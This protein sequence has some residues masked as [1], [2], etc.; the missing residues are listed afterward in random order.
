[1][2]VRQPQYAAPIDWSNPI[3]RGLAVAWVPGIATTPAART[4]V[5]YGA[6]AVGYQGVAGKG[7]GS[8]TFALLPGTID[9][10]S[11]YGSIASADGA[12]TFLAVTKVGALTSQQH[13]LN[14][15]DGV[16]TALGFRTNTTSIGLSQ[17]SG[18]SILNFTSAVTAGESCVVC[19][20]GRNGSTDF[21]KNGRFVSN[22]SV[23][24]AGVITSGTPVI[25]RSGTSSQYGDHEISL[26]VAFNRRLSRSEGESLTANPWQI[27]LAPT[28]RVWIA[29]S[30]GGQTLTPSLYTN[31]NTFYGPTVTRGAVTLSPARYTNTNTFYTATVT[32]SGAPQTLQPSLFANSNTFYTPTV[33]RGAVQLTPAL[34]VNTNTFYAA[35][36]TQA[37]NQTLTPSLFVNQNTFYTP[38]IGDGKTTAAAPAASRSRRATR[39][40]LVIVE[41]DGVE[42]RVL[43]ENLDEFIKSK[44]K[45]AKQEAKKVVKSTE[46]Y[47]ILPAF[48]PIIIRQVEQAPVEV[49]SKVVDRANQ[50]MSDIWNSLIKAK[51]EKKA[52]E[53]QDEEDDLLTILLG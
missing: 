40:P 7:N 12:V 52:K 50:A 32:Q 21:F 42:Y 44:K 46:T 15:H 13:F 20:S 16:G 17:A 47:E 25:G 19:V 29:P 48:Q 8:S 14:T 30:S 1:M 11:A 49:V 31:T 23:S 39:K 10:S 27:F 28:R 38:Q 6:A 9:A 45:E 35:T 18:G 33:S 5:N 43:L 3:T 22:S 41:I 24:Y 4:S 36:V 26:L 37:T 2:A 51:I 53:S 34:F